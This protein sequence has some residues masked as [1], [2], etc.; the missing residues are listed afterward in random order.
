[1]NL[2][3]QVWLLYHQQNFL[4]ILHF[5]YKR[6]GITDRRTDKRTDGRSDY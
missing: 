6:D 2:Q 3:V 1:M 4:K 5:V